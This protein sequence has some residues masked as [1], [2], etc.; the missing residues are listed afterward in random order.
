MDVY[1]RL[2]AT[3]IAMIVRDIPAEFWTDLRALAII[4]YADGKK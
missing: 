3:A 2:R 4:A 1:E